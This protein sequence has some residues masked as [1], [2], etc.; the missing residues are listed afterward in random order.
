MVLTDSGGV[1]KEAYF[2]NKPCIIIRSETEWV[3]V[4]KAGAA[5]ICDAD[6]NKIIDAFNFYMTSNLKSL[7]TIFG[8]GKAADFIIKKIIQNFK[9]A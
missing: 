5:R 8:N 9:N 2:Y 1:Q 7:P 4:V 6:E 3:E